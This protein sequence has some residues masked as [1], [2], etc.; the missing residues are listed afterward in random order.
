MQDALACRHMGRVI[1]AFREH[2]LHGRESISQGT[3]AAWIGITQAQISRIETP[4]ASI[5]R[6]FL[7]HRA[8]LHGN[9]RW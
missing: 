2:P 7:C 5:A 9:C 3:V 8:T 6:R 4:G 1:R